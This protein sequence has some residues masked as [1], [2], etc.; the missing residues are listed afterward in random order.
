MAAYFVLFV[1]IAMTGPLFS[2]NVSA[3]GST[4]T[5][6]ADNATTPVDTI[7]TS[8]AGKTPYEFYPRS[9]THYKEIRDVFDINTMLCYF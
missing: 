6:M 3:Q 5:S 8:Q 4:T 2:R 9:S 1:A 7:P